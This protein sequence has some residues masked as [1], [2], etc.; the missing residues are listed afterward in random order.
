[1]LHPPAQNRVQRGAAILCH[2][3][4]SDKNSA[5]LV[6]LSRALAKVGVAALR[7]DFSFVG[8]SS[9]NF[10]DLTVNGEV[11]D[12]R[13]AYDLMKQRYPGKIAIFGSSMGGTVALLFAAQQPQ[14]AVLATLAA[15][16]HPEEFPKRILTPAEL[17]QW[18][19]Q[20]FA[21]Y[22]RRRLNV[23]LLED[24]DRIDVVDAAKKVRCPALILH[25]AVDQVVPVEEAH[26]LYGC[27]MGVKRLSILSGADHRLSE[28]AMMQLAMAEALVWL[29]EHVG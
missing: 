24:L 13:A 18:R 27:L 22:N 21:I 2:G 8:S 19:A 16:L 20:G 6:F 10:E 5:K 25:G 7:F 28:P 14:V 26:E 11:D 9:G 3:M 29:T 23:T 12:L 1:V 15:P 4:D 17:Q